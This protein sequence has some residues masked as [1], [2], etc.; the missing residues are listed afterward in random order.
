M[1]DRT[2]TPTLALPRYT[3]TYVVRLD[4][5]MGTELARRHVAVTLPDGSEGTMA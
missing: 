2:P 3:L 4:K 1:I 5:D